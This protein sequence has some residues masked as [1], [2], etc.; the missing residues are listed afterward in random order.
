MISRFW[1]KP[2]NGPQ[3]EPTIRGSGRSPTM[4]RVK[5]L[6][7]PEMF[8]NQVI[9]QRSTDWDSTIHTFLKSSYWVNGVELDWW[10][11]ILMI[12][13]KV[14]RRDCRLIKKTTLEMLCTQLDWNWT[15]GNVEDQ[16]LSLLLNML[17]QNEFAI[18]TWQSKAIYNKGI[19][20]GTLNGYMVHR[21]TCYVLFKLDKN[22]V[23]GHP[24]I[25][26]AQG[27]HRFMSGT[28]ENSR[29]SKSLST[30]SPLQIL[31]ER[32]LGM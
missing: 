30:S 28:E 19:W 8:I 11:L 15:Q 32:P 3:F 27:K 1:E 13:G 10:I 25:I 26:T 12:R 24:V 6:L 18:A 16:T 29:G 14:D 9:D 4:D 23:K 20:S 21:R 7:P 22:I 17:L 2:H 5:N 31:Q